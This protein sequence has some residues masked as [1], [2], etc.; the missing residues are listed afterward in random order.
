[1]ALPRVPNDLTLAPVAVSIDQHLQEFRDRDAKE[2][3]A[4][5]EL[6][7]DRPEF[8]ASPEERCARILEVVVRNTNMHGWDAQITSDHARLR[9]TGGSVSLDIGLSASIHDFIEVTS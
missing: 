3:L 5:L 2:I 7:L 8:A 1:M 4:Y 9:I 6:E